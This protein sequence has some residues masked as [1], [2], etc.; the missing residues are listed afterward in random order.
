M[1]AMHVYGMTQRSGADTAEH[2]AGHLHTV[3]S[4]VADNRLTLVCYYMFYSM[5]T[6]MTDRY[7]MSP[8]LCPSECLQALHIEPNTYKN[9]SSSDHAF[10][11]ELL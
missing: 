1:H 3:I 11:S 5:C 7:T 8:G 10:N 6:F 4:S 2:L 9:A